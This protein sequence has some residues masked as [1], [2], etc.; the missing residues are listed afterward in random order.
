MNTD[1]IKG[2]TKM[3]IGKVQE[4]AGNL[5]DDPKLVV[6]G[7]AKQVAGRAQKGRG[8]IKA[9]ISSYRRQHPGESL[10]H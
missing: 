7:I 6:M 10:R 5:V 3:V 2:A 1:Q 8:D 4:Q 9:K